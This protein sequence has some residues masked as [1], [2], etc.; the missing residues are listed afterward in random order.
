MLSQ[1]L[2]NFKNFAKYTKLEIF[3]KRLLII[4]LLYEIAFFV[5]LDE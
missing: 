3:S 5:S 1:I 4:V 2:Y